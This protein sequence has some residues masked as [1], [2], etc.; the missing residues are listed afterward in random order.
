MLHALN[1]ELC[2]CPYA[3]RAKIVLK[4]KNLSF[5]TTYIDGKDKSQDF[6]D[7]FRSIT[8]NPTHR[9]TVPVLIGKFCE[10]TVAINASVFRTS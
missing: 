1:F 7:L 4:E 9:G 5:E 3:Q 6:V 10:H 2:S 8:Q